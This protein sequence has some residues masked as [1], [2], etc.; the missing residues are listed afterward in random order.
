MLNVGHN[1]V[2]ERPSDPLDIQSVFDFIRVPQQD[3]PQMFQ[4]WTKFSIADVGFLFYE[5]TIC[6]R[7]IFVSLDRT[8]TVGCL[9]RRRHHNSTKAV[10]LSLQSP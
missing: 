8:Q 7:F 2:N 6:G 5:S 4:F 3:S 1:L 9:H 10:K